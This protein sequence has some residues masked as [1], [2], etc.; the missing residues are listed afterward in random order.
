MNLDCTKKTDSYTVGSSPLEIAIPTR[1]ISSGSDAFLYWRNAQFSSDGRL[2]SIGKETGSICFYVSS[3]DSFDPLTKEQRMQRLVERMEK[4]Q[5]RKDTG[6]ERKSLLGC[7]KR[8]VKHSETN[9][10]TAIEKE[11]SHTTQDCTQ[12]D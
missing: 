5:A 3:G 4:R 1:V 6:H 7:L 8:R 11:L 12:Q 9:K 10:T 2:L